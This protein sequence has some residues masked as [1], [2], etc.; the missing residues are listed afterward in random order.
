M[1]RGETWWHACS[2]SPATPWIRNQWGL[3]WGML[4]QKALIKRSSLGGWKVVY[5]LHC[6]S[7][8]GPTR[9]HL[10]NTFHLP[11][12]GRLESPA[13]WINPWPLNTYFSFTAAHYKRKHFTLNWFFFC[14]PCQVFL[15][16]LH[17]NCF[18]LMINMSRG[19]ACFNHVQTMTSDKLKKTKVKMEF[20]F[21]V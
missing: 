4:S 14:Y 17:V 3:F 1:L 16:L 2:Y 20:H 19:A 5:Q 12:S 11:F 6:H 15:L 8:M 13:P 7:L 9:L 21:L 10:V 18:S